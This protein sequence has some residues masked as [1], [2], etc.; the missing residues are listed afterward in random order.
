M[1]NS[2]NPKLIDSQID[3]LLLKLASTGRPE[4]AILTN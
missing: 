3:T 2:P 4:I 1:C